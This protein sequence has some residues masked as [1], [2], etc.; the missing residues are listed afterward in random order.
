M[1]RIR[2]VLSDRFEADRQAMAQVRT[3]LESQFPDVSSSNLDKIPDQLRNSLHYRLQ[4]SLYVAESKSGSVQGFALLMYAPDLKFAFLD[5]IASGRGG[6]SGG[7]GSALYQRV[8]EEATH[9][10]IKG[11][12]ME[13]LP[14]DP[15]L[16]RSREFLEQN[17]ARL[18]FYER[19]GAFPLINTLYETPVK[20][21]DDCPPYLV[22][23]FLG[24]SPAD[25]KSM[26]L[27]IRAILE[28]KYGDYCP[29]GYID[30]VVKSVKDNP[31]QL[32]PPKYV[33]QAKPEYNLPVR[34]T[35]KIALVVN[36]KHTIHHI[37]D[38]GYVEAPV[39]ISSIL[40][41]IEP[42]G[43]FVQL[44]PVSFSERW[45][46]R[47]HDIGYIEY[48][49]RVCNSLPE[50]KSIYPYVFPI[51]NRTRPPADDSVLAGY[52]CIDTFTPL[53]RNAWLAAKRAVDC[54]LTCADA[55][56]EGRKIAYSLIRPPGHHAEKTVFGG[57]CYF[58]SA[59]VAAEYLSGYGRVAILDI[60]YHHGNGQQ[61]IFYDRDDVLTVSL[62][63]DPS[64]AY[65]YF[66]GYRDETGEGSGAGYNI[67]FTLKELTDGEIYRKT[68]KAA[69]RAIKKFSPDFLVVAF[70]LD[71][72]KNDP[73]GTW[74]L[75]GADFLANGQ[76][77]GMAGLPVLVVQ[78]G[79]YHT[80]S[81]GINTRNFFK[82]LHSELYR[83]K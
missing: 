63:G 80:R 77:I 21:G 40:K 41:H 30:M 59:A 7:I 65:P 15:A 28:R 67:N 48:F 18:K 33:K 13:C 11:L 79:G 81:L 60:D 78:E 29:A 62:H 4:T 47:I 43:L 55:L 37:Q 52:Y 56:I 45:I 35:D 68:L 34:Q 36:D 14:D 38:R 54:T 83:Q 42:T 3:I 9:M 75:T 53:N 74:S 39:R 2:R 27:I 12:F 70:G 25:R 17:R 31:V 51:R 1:F 73:T 64:F 22:C 57:F 72:A 76:L 69:L 24:G 82:G 26:Q 61:D 71:T 19:F 20:E 10:G 16:C 6:T 49:R 46:R 23:D 8:R 58:N 44:K 50:G 66:S 32:R 5:Y